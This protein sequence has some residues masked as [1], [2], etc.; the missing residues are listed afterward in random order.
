M[1]QNG[2]DNF[3]SEALRNGSSEDREQIAIDLLNVLHR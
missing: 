1:R 3:E 2:T